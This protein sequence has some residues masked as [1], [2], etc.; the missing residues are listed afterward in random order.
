MVDCL[1]KLKNSRYPLLRVV[2]GSL[3]VVSG[4]EKLIG[5]YQNFVYVIQ[6]YSFLPLALAEMVARLLPWAEF[7]LGIFLVLGLWTKWTLRALMA[8]LLMFMG[9]VIQALIRQLP[10]TECGCFGG[11]IS[12]PL[13]VILAFDTT[14]LVFAWF[15]SFRMP[16]A[17]R[18]SM[19]RYFSKNE[20]A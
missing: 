6:N 7:F 5:P 4:F 10:I 3:F 17:K 18:C 19:D 20:N 8:L 12:F 14:A 15:L 13:P 9:V 2:I 11:L 1:L 16:E